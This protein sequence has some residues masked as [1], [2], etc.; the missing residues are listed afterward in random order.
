MNY[1]VG[2]TVVA[3][4]D[5]IMEDGERSFT[6]GKSYVIKHM[7]G[8]SCHLIDDYNCYH[9]MDD[10]AMEEA[11]GHNSTNAFDDAMSVI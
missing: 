3:T 11:F 1:K 2:D 7:G 8:G 6:A 10:E 5:Y 9:G 4:E